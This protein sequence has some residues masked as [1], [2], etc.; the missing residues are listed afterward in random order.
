[1]I[2]EYIIN[3]YK[4]SCSDD[5]N[6]SKRYQIHNSVIDYISILTKGNELDTVD[7]LTIGFKDVCDIITKY[8]RLIVELIPKDDISYIITTG[9]CSNPLLNQMLSNTL[10]TNC[11]NIPI[12]DEKTQKGTESIGA[13][14][15]G[16]KYGK[17]K[18]IPVIV[19]DIVVKLNN[20][21]AYLV[22]KYTVLPFDSNEIII[23]LDG[24]IYKYNIDICAVGIDKNEVLIETI[25][26]NS[27]DLVR[28]SISI[29]EKEKIILHISTSKDEIVLF[30]G[31]NPYY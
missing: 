23:S 25:P 30:P 3:Y 7:D 15:Y 4:E 14:I 24:A 26:I 21:N 16:E 28:I 31:F 13:A 8:H 29:D 22:K 20:G 18:I 10:K 6:T 5:I 1:M 9:T 12:L 2:E 17:Y 11:I 27:S 19:Y